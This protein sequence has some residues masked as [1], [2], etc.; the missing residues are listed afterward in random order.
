M[1]SD[2]LRS[3]GKLV[4]CDDFP[5]VIRALALAGAKFVVIG[6]VANSRNA[7]RVAAALMQFSPRPRGMPLDLPFRLDDRS[8]LA[9]QVLTLATNVG[10]CICSEKSR[11]CS[12]QSAAGRE[13]D[14]PGILELEALKKI[15]AAQG[16]A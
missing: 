13:K 7:R 3:F 5:E 11:D 14:R 1:P 8:L 2:P 10:T 4:A 12:Q 6:G 16:E 15:R 9:S